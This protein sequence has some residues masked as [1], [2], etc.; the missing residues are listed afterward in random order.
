MFVRLNFE[1]S[2]GEAADDLRRAAFGRE[3]SAA[4]LALPAKLLA[5]IREDC[6]PQPE[7]VITVEGPPGD[8]AILNSGSLRLR[9]ASEI[10]LVPVDWLWQDM[11]P[12]GHLTLLAGREGVG[13][14]TL[15]YT[16][17]AEVTRGW[18]TGSQEE[19]PAPVIIV[20]TEDSWS[21]TIAPRLVAAKADM[22][23]V[24]ALELQ[25]EGGAYGIDLPE[26][27]PELQ[28]LLEVRPGA[29]VLL[30]PLISRLNGKLDT[31]KDAEVRRGLEPLV[32]CL[33]DTGATALGLIH[34]SK[35]TT[36]DPL[37]AVMASR[38]FVGVAR[39]VL[40]VA[41]DP[42]EPEVRYVQLV[43]SN[44][45]STLIPTMTFSISS[46]TLEGEGHGPVQVGK[47]HWGEDSGRTVHEILRFQTGSA[48]GPTN[49]EVARQW[50]LSF[51]ADQGGRHEST[52]IKAAANA[53]G[54]NT[55]AL[56][57]ARQQ[58]GILDESTAT[59][60][61]T[62]VWCTPEG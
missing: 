51:M 26:H 21:S 53:A 17:A 8:N 3:A 7:V 38:A 16:L 60:P 49:V 50:L 2:T 4:A 23:L 20:A 30:D 15:A 41:V 34:V 36:T 62:T 24:F 1:G 12:K 47:L 31:H 42:D 37:T 33:D 40:F 48:S 19:Q 61:R 28:K 59:Y 39:S 10:P 6:G 43:K 45:G 9:Q 22:K 35:S 58:L 32:R 46:K 52:A 29:L 11:I 54:I 14:S 44:L 57:R 56:H 27:V 18:L 25:D 55:S 5:A 13:K